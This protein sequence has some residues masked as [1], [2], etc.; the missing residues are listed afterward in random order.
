MWE[1]IKN[2]VGVN[3]KVVIGVA[4]AI[5]V[6][7]IVLLIVNAIINNYTRRAKS[8]RAITLAKL[9]QS[10]LR[11]V[12]IILA[13]I[14]I[15]NIIGFDVVPLLAGA[16][17]AGLVIGLGAQ[18]IIS[19][20]LAG[21]SITFEDYYELDE[22]VEIKGFKGTVIEV[23]LR[24]T[25]LRNWKGEVKII[26]NGEI[27]EITNFSRSFSMAVVKVVIGYNE[28]I[29]TAISILEENLPSLNES[30]SQIIEGPNIVGVSDLKDKGVEIQINAKTISEQHYSVERAMRKKVKQILFKNNISV[31]YPQLVLHK[32]DESDKRK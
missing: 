15:I 1:K 12:I 32:E 25:K 27:K 30:F 23:G 7:I 24:S 13:I 17:I 18:S 5:F 31:P 26:A 16:G 3:S 9:I 14:I 4:V 11:Y 22:V 10:I 29:D 8:K 6:T 19:D 20:F 21:I 28:N 2:F